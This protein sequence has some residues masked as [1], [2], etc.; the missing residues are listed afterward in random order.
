MDIASDQV[1]GFIDTKAYLSVAIATIPILPFTATEVARSKW[2]ASA[3]S[4]GKREGP[5]SALVYSFRG[6]LVESLVSGLCGEAS[7]GHSILPT[8]RGVLADDGVLGV[9]ICSFGR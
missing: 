9:L 3:A 6:R 8:K 2:L 5:A 1:S 4:P 7:V